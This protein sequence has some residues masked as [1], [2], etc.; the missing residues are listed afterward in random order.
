ML[1]RSEHCVIMLTENIHKEVPSVNRYN[2]EALELTGCEQ[3]V[4]ND[5]LGH[6]RFPKEGDKRRILANVAGKTAIQPCIQEITKTTGRITARVSTKNGFRQVD[7]MVGGNEVVTR[8]LRS[9]LHSSLREDEIQAG[10]DWVIGN[11]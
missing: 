11:L 10:I 1:T 4:L 9:R 6:N 5:T 2:I 3:S 8:E 7:F